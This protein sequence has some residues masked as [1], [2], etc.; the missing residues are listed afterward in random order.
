MNKIANFFLFSLIMSPF[1]YGSAQSSDQQ[2]ITETAQKLITLLE[3]NDSINIFKLHF[4]YSESLKGTSVY[5]EALKRFAGDC[6]NFKYMLSSKL[7]SNKDVFVINKG[8]IDFPEL[9]L[10]FI[11]KPDTALQIFSAKLIVRFYPIKYGTL[12]KIFNYELLI[13]K[14]KNNQKREIIQAPLPTIN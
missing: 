7:I 12:D 1:Y 14:R 2:K 11:D 3:K 4:E 6:S 9:E 8:I 13:D 5:N 10:I